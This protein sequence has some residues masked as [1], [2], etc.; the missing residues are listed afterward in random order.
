M[1][2]YAIIAIVMACFGISSKEVNATTLHRKQIGIAS[3]YGGKFIGRKTASGQIFS[4]RKFT[5]AHKTLP[6][7]TTLKVHSFD[8]DKEIIVVVNDRGP[9]VKGRVVDLSPIAAN[10]LGFGGKKGIGTNKVSIT[11]I[12]IP[13]EYAE[14]HEKKHKKRS[15]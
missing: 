8:T 11:P 7:G 12:K 6:L 5:C 10:A 4:S 14:Y 3:W 2:K 13:T 15:K 1:K 9:Y